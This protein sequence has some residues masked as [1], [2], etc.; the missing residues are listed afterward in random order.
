M[1]EWLRKAQHAGK[2]VLDG[3]VNGTLDK[4]KDVAEDAA[5]TT[6][7]VAEDFGGAAKRKI[8]ELRDM[9]TKELIDEVKGQLQRARQLPADFDLELGRVLTG[10]EEAITNL[11]NNP[12]GRRRLVEILESI[13]IDHA[14]HI[15]ERIDP[16]QARRILTI[17][18]EFKPELKKHLEEAELCE[19]ALSGDMDAHEELVRRRLQQNGFFARNAYKFF[20]WNPFVKGQHIKLERRMIQAEYIKQL[21]AITAKYP[22]FTREFLRKVIRE[23]NTP[24][25]T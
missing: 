18:I 21:D 19:R 22:F 3:N 7:D 12:E 6:K 8:E 20:R 17:L 24:L 4:V 9:D 13:T 14:R 16:K 5:K 2:D 23:G 1:N 10:E 25:S 11:L 15:L